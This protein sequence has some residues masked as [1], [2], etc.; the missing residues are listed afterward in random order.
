MILRILVIIL[1][2]GGTIGA[3]VGYGMVRW[4]DDRRRHADWERETEWLS[5]ESQEREP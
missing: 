4:L 1:L 2:V 3:L 5:R